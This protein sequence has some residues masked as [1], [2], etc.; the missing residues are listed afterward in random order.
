VTKVVVLDDYQDVA[1]G[2][3]SWEQ[4]A[5]TIELTVLHE[6]VDDTEELVARLAGAQVVV[7]MRE[8]TPFDQR[9]LERL[10]DLRLLVTT[11]MANAAIDLQAA[12]DLGITVCGTATP[13]H[14]RRG[15]P[16]THCE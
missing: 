10:T 13:P 1:R 11:G 15:P 3:G 12:R 7:A 9:R 5:D 16:G 4:L 14:G 6:H 8:R 2:L